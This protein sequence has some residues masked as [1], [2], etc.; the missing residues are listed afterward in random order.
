MPLVSGSRMQ[1]RRFNEERSKEPDMFQYAFF[2]SSHF[3]MRSIVPDS[4]QCNGI[5]IDT[6]YLDM[7][8]V[9]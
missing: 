5:R 9:L 6:G 3:Y 7:G 8:S 2:F 1:G 4:A